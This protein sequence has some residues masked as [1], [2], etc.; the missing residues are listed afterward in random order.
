MGSLDFGAVPSPHD[1][2]AAV[3]IR[4]RNHTKP[5]DQA[6][7]GGFVTCSGT[8]PRERPKR[9]NPNQ[10]HRLHNPGAVV[11]VK[12]VILE[13][14]T[15]WT[16]AGRRGSELNRAGF[17]AVVVLMLVH[18]G[19]ATQPPT[20]AL[21]SP[22]FLMGLLHGIVVPFSF[23]GSLLSRDIRIYAFPN[24]GVL[25]D[26]GFLLGVSARAW[27]GIAVS[28]EGTSPGADIDEV[29]NLQRIARRL[30]RRLRGY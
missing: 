5:R 4:P 20:T 21:D 1:P 2:K 25:Y 11:V 15:L 19:C 22:G 24:S 3:Q 17:L 12:G 28:A 27:G 29:H 10:Q 7:L 6:N 16:R 13:T 30:R 18:A 8:R 9:N 26:F 14:V 23:I